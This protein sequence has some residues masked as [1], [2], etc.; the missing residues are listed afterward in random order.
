[1]KRL[2]F[3]KHYSN[4]KR[5]GSPGGRWWWAVYPLMGNNRFY[6]VCLNVTLVKHFTNTWG[7]FGTAKNGDWL[8][9]VTII[10]RGKCHQ[11]SPC[12]VFIVSIH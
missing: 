1:M 6:A 11:Y 7:G 3:V 2:L 8:R 9:P 12:D 5:I 10:T 4:L